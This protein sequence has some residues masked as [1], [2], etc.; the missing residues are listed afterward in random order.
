MPVP[1]KI[2]SPTLN[3]VKFMYFRISLWFRSAEENIC[4]VEVKG[5]AIMMFGGNFE[6]ITA[7]A[8]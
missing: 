2:S 3:I 6:T 7:K 4:S 8:S 1:A 5:T